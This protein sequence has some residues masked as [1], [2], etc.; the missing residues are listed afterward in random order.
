MRLSLLVLLRYRW[1]LFVPGIEFRCVAQLLEEPFLVRGKSLGNGDPQQHEMIAP[2]S[3]ANAES[4][5][6]QPQ[7]LT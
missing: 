3:P 2:A 7:L 6:F 5:T 4:L 1:S